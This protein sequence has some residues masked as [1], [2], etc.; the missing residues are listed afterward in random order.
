AP[1]VPPDW[2]VET[3]RLQFPFPD[4]YQATLDGL[5]GPAGIAVTR[6]IDSYPCALLTTATPC[7]DLVGPGG[8]VLCVDELFAAD[9]T[10]ETT[11]GETFTHF[12]ALPPANDYAALCPAGSAAGCTG[13]ASAL[14]FTIDAAG[15]VL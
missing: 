9:G 6:G 5:A 12:T 13:L 8:P 2:R 15:N 11:P 1:G 4:T 14:A 3:D 7:R 10:C